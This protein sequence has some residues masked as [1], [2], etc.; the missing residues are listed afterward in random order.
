L[1]GPLSVA[2]GCKFKL[3]TRLNPLKRLTS[4]KMADDNVKLQNAVSV[5]Q[6]LKSQWDMRPPNLEECGKLLDNLKVH[7]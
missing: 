2:Q 6:N 4:R 3:D 5:Y 1:F 7:N